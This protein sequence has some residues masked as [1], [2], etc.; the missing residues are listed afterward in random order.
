M[1]PM[2]MVRAGGRGEHVGDC[3]AKQLAVIGWH[4]VGSLAQA[5]TRKAVRALVD[6]AYPDARPGQRIMTATQLWRFAH[7]I[8]VGDRVVMYDASQRIYHVGTVAGAY[9]HQETGIAEQMNTRA[10]NWQSMV[11]R[12]SLSAGTRNSL[13]SIMTLFRLPELAAAEIEALAAGKSIQRPMEAA[14]QDAAETEDQLLIDVEARALEFTKDHL[15]RLS[16]EQM[17]ELVAGVLR[18]MGYKTRVSPAGSDRG[19]D[20]VASPDGLGFENPR[21]VVEVKH[22]AGAMGAPQIRSFMGGR[23][24]DDKCLY[25]SSGGFTKE[26]RYEADRSQIPLTLL[27]LDGLTQ[28]LL[29]HYDNLDPQTRQL[30]PLKRVYWPV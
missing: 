28:L 15:H 22:R 3:I 16:P 25:V 23:H 18:A 10:M 27:D 30:V 1:K 6:K 8:A 26:A 12:D 13:G 20:I 2:W 9:V 7:E 17:P 29:E 21:I 14:E 5:R 19:K 11:D 24:K 4:E